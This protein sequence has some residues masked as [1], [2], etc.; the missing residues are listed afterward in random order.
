MMSILPYC[1]KINLYWSIRYVCNFLFCICWAATCNTQT[2]CLYT[3]D[4]FIAKNIIIIK[5]YH[6][7]HTVVPTQKYCV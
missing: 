5:K 1:V 4:I 2:R 7:D 6:N 3:V